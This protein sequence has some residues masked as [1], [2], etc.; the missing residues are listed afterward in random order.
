MSLFDLGI[1]VSAIAL[2]VLVNWFFLGSKGRPV[3]VARDGHLLETASKQQRLSRT[4]FLAA[5]RQQGIRKLADVDLAVLEADGRISFFT[6]SDA[7]D[8]GSPETSNLG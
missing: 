1:A 7:P 4:D 8:S 5:A 3:V 6:R 2:I